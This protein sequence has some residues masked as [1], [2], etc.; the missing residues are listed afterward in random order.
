MYQGQV[1]FNE[2]A[3]NYI[4]LH[5]G[6][7]VYLT[8]TCALLEPGRGAPTFVPIRLVLTN[9]QV[10]FKSEHSDT[11][12][13]IFYVPL[14]CI[15]KLRREDQ[16]NYQ[17]IHI[18]T[19]TVQLFVLRFQVKYAAEHES[20]F[21]CWKYLSN[22]PYQPFTDFFC[23][24][25]AVA[26][27]R[28][29]LHSVLGDNHTPPTNGTLH[30][31]ASDMHLERAGGGEI[32]SVEQEFLRMVGR[33]EALR[34]RWRVSHA[35][36][37]FRI[38]PTY[39]RGIILPAAF[40]DS[41]LPAVAE[42]REKGRFPIISWIHPS[43]GTVLAR[44]SQPR[45]A[46]F[47]ARCSADERLADLLSPQRTGSQGL[48][49]ADARA[50][51]SA[52][53]NVAKGGGYEVPDHY[54]QAAHLNLD[55][56][57]IHSIRE[58]WERLCNLSG[59]ARD[60]WSTERWLG[61]LVGT[62][63]LSHVTKIMKK[64]F[65]IAL[66]L[67]EQRSSVLV[68]CS[69]GWDRTSQLCALSSLLL[70]PYY[71]T[72][73]GFQILIEKEWLSAGHHFAERCGTTGTKPDEWFS[74]IF[75][76]WMDCVWQVWRQHQTAFEFTDIYLNYIVEHVYACR[77]GT[78]LCNS[79][80]DRMLQGVSNRSLSLWDNINAKPHR[81]YNL[82]YDK[83]NPRMLN[84]SRHHSQ[85]VLWDSLYFTFHNCQSVWRQR[86]FGYITVANKLAEL[87]QKLAEL[88]AHMGED[89]DH[90]GAATDL[91]ANGDRVQEMMADIVEGVVS[92]A[93][94]R[95]AEREVLCPDGLEWAADQAMKWV[96]DNLSHTC[97]FCHKPF[98]FWRRRHHCRICG[99]LF[100]HAD[101]E[102]S[103]AGVRQCR[104]CA[105]HPSE[106]TPETSG[107]LR[108]TI[109]MCEIFGE[110]LPLPCEIVRCERRD[111]DNT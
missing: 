77:F 13:P 37:R 52:L 69:D 60:S 100:C 17:L 105:A 25:T 107:V 90:P 7:T 2:H 108:H 27:L 93:L 41:D 50:Y 74:P 34:P 36:R 72:I 47:S 6:E 70:D 18:Q 101:C 9:Y 5:N 55:L 81:F 1:R 95:V 31:M 92:L 26:S 33:N 10:V 76:L 12:H 35:N 79:V 8:A 15:Y 58:S 88:N 106:Q 21:A 45:T 57:N 43:N 24:V 73:L 42:F 82:L 102:V 111:R 48:V 46:G 104:K 96:P 98:T 61:E 63:W 40:P 78:F 80:R 65:Q 75:L 91:P 32:Y 22:T 56:A 51:S 23:W 4:H 53:G 62:G 28:D 68:H 29:S 84:P 64:S 109:V 94:S 16:D 44:C 39:P 67:E 3:L 110:I 54:R 87:Q 59:V 83:R 103:A 11:K 19:K 85:I 20:F 38:C 99:R 86:S 49:I 89:Q 71:R 30:Y 66:H 97:S 14:M